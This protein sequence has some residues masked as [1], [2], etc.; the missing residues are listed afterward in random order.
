[1]QN[2]ENQNQGKEIAVLKHAENI[3]LNQPAGKIPGIKETENPYVK[4][5]SG[6]MF[7]SK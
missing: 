4:R 3:N 7:K 6:R 2:A 1:M 5:R